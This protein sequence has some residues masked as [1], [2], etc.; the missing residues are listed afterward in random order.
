MNDVERRQL[1]EALISEIQ[2]YEEK[3]PNGQWLKSITFK[4]PII[5]EDLNIS[6]ENDEQVDGVSVPGVDP[7]TGFPLP[8]IGGGTGVEVTFD[9][10]VE[11]IPNP[12]PT[13]NIANID[14]SYTPVE[15]GIPND[16]SVDSN[17]VPV[18]VISADIEVT[19]LSE[20]TIVNP[21]EELI[22]TI[23]VVNNGPFHLK[24][25]F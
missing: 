13:N 1:I 24:M 7:N 4:L 12:N 19:K 5:D 23:K 18:E 22:Y 25:W 20:P 8:D 14:Y 6:L 17:P 2:I 10:V 9:V 21:G 16:F 3:Q 15:G 11:S